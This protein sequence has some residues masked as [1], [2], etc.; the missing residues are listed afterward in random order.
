VTQLPTG[1]VTFLFTDLEGSTRLWEEHPEAMRAALARHDEILREAI[2]AHDGHVVKMTGDGVHAAFGAPG[3]AVN[4]ARDAQVALADEQWNGVDRLRVRMGI[5]T[6]QAALRDGDYYG[7]AVNR[8]ARLMS[9][10]NAGQVVVSL[11]TE[12]L[13]RDELSV[14]MSLVDLGEHRLR[15]LARPEHIFQLAAPGLDTTFASLRTLDA[16]S[17]NLPQHVTSFV[18]RDEALSAVADA[19][20]DSRVVTVTGVGGVGKTRL[21]TQ[22]AA[23]VL[24]AFADGAWLCELAAAS[25][26]ESMIQLVASTLGVTPRPGI[27]LDASVVE[28]LEPKQLL[29]VL[30][31]CEH[32]LEPVARLADVIV[33]RC[34]STRLLVTSREGLGIAGEQVWPLRSLALSRD[35]SGVSDAVQLFAD[36]ARA[37][38]PGFVLDDG[39]AESVGEVCARLDG[40][41]LAIELAAA[42]VTV[43]SPAEISGHLDERF[44]LLTGGRRTAVERHQT[45]RAAVDWSYSLLDDA[46]RAVFDRLGVFAGTFDAE[47]A[48]AVAASAGVERW[49]V[50]DA[51]TSLVAK[52][53]VVVEE[54]HGGT[55]YQL[56]ETLRHYA[57][58]RLDDAGV[59]DQVRRAHAVQYCERA[60]YLGPLLQGPEEISARSRVLVD[61]DDLRAA[62]YWAADRGSEDGELAVRVVAALATEAIQGQRSGIGAWATRLVP[63]AYESTPGRRMAALAAAASQAATLGDYDAAR[64]YARDAIVEPPPPDCPAA[65]FA[66][67]AQQEVEAYEGRPGEAYRLN[68]RARRVLEAASAHTFSI[69]LLYG[70]AS[71]WAISLGD[72]ATARVDAEEA[73][74]LG[75]AI[76]NP[77]VISTASVDL[78]WALADDEPDRALEHFEENISLVRS[79][80]GDGTY[81]PALAMAAAL[82]AR[83]GDDAAAAARLVE[84]I[85][86]ALRG[87]MRVTLIGNLNWGT[88]VCARLGWPEPAALMYGIV[89]VGPLEAGIANYHSSSGWV[90]TVERTR[91]ELGEQ[92]FADLVRRGS[93]MSC[94][95]VVVWLRELLDELR[96]AYGAEHV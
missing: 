77:T 13:T 80:A 30:D 26:A 9:V 93:A 38:H 34:P 17:N 61:L 83:R 27:T 49:D 31:N 20:A 76:Q 56:L 69:G 14:D 92:R 90:E 50:L 95:E 63:L 53:M 35:G 28:F 96:V 67:F 12:E 19:L 81:S 55:R 73:L 65:W 45:L 59:S 86:Y 6:G 62:V 94:E 84:A 87:G 74:R 25:D 82:Y 1:T 47:S 23:E 18:G 68:E 16:Y 22:A 91:H 85:G 54:A 4:A 42:R 71:V 44:R 29:L 57:R 3:D 5:H 40:I 72:F 46:E 60:E 7:T 70:V 2:A 88:E 52:S 21:A 58:E 89:R 11:A 48:A 36:R 15:D 64:R 41:P 43:M 37:A 33:Q 39:H 75:R 10:A 78:G 51:L 79:G 66:Y 24:P 32:R 8:A